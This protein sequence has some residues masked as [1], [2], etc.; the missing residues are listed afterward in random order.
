MD[1]FLLRLPKASAKKK[2]LISD[3]VDVPL[4]DAVKAP[5]TQMYLD[6]GQ[7]SF[8]ATTIC[9][10]CGLLYVINDAEDIS[11]HKIY[12]RTVQSCLALPCFVIF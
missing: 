4:A 5:R 9:E 3:A 11:R 8:G 6:F 1:G 2:R 12:C 10:R 7:K